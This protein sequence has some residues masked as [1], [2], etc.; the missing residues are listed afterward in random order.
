MA[1]RSAELADTCLQDRNPPGADYR[2]NRDVSQRVLHTGIRKLPGTAM[3]ISYKTMRKRI[4]E[5][6][7]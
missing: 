5:D 1:Q 2:A 4:R 7:T 3:N 6:F